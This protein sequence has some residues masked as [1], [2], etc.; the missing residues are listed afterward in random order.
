MVEDAW[1]PQQAPDSLL[2]I[3]VDDPSESQRLQADHEVRLQETANFH[4]C[5]PEIFTRSRRPAVR[6]AKNG[7]LAD[8]RYMDDGDILCHPVLVPSHLQEF[9]VANAKVGAERNPQNG[10][11]LLQRTAWV[12]HLLSEKLMMY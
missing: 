3:G 6:A 4:F 2:W 11:H 9:D 1:L 5:G 8:V 12:Q 7:G 10:G